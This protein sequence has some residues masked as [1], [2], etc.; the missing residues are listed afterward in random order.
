MLVSEFTDH[1]AKLTGDHAVHD[2]FDHALGAACVAV[3]MNREHRIVLRIGRKHRRAAVDDS[4][5]GLS[6]AA[7]IAHDAVLESGIADNL[8]GVGIRRLPCG[9]IRAALPFVRNVDNDRILMPL[10][11]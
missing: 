7:C 9:I 4:C 3:H 6:P 2:V 8:H 5:R 10:E 11:R 1:K